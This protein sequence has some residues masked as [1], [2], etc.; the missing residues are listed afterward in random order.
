MAN[1]FMDF[2]TGGGAYADPNQ[3]DP[4][5]GA[6]YGAVRQAFFNQLGNVGAALMAAGQPVEPAVRAQLLAQAGGFGSGMQRDIFNASQSRLMQSQ[7]QTAEQERQR[8]R[9]LGERIK[10][11]KFLKE[12]GLTED[13]ATALGPRGVADVLEKKATQD[14]MERV[15]KSLQVQKLQSDIDE[16]KLARQAIYR[17]YGLEEGGAAGAA[18]PAPATAGA[19]PQV[20]TS[21][22]AA[23][24]TPG[25]FPA[26]GARIPLTPEMRVRIAQDPKGAFADLARAQQEL[27][28]K[29]VRTLS[30]EERSQRGITAGPNTIV[31]ESRT[32]EITFKEPK[33]EEMESRQK[34][35]GAVIDYVIK[36]LRPK[37]EQAA[38]KILPNL[39]RMDELLTDDV[40]TGAAANQEVAVRKIASLFGVGDTR[41]I[42]NTEQLRAL[43]A[44]NVLPYMDA[45][46]GSDTVEEMKLVEGIVAGNIALQKDTIQAVVRGMEKS[47][48]NAVELYDRERA[49]IEQYLPKGSGIVK[50]P[51]RPA[52]ATGE[53]YRVINVR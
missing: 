35:R 28:I 51:E 7:V 27:A 1:G 9:N 49:T 17:Y 39:Y 20:A 16:G 52:K 34:G 5:T 40:I 25:A 48:R 13:Q 32:G 19:M 12:I 3:V 23:A 2:L 31:Q 36:D 53:G 43:M 46:G 6:P 47:A 8:L 18:A 14:P 41:K 42:S 50:I 15:L 44:E 30:P 38:T 21:E 45:F 37:A 26:Q 33:D 22:P 10:D 29:G 24:P 4:N 11:P